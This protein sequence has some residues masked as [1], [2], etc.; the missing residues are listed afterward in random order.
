MLIN[1]IISRQTPKNV[2]FGVILPSNLEW[3]NWKDGVVAA[4]SETV[5]AWKHEQ[6]IK[7]EKSYKIS[8]S[9]ETINMIKH[10]CNFRIVAMQSKHG[11]V[12]K[13]NVAQPSPWCSIW[14]Y[15]AMLYVNF[16]CF[17][18]FDKYQSIIII[19]LS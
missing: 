11:A 12:I 16:R 10:I 15:N 5:V 7:F 8:Q 14:A 4:W 17:N 2:N 9:N 13:L 1:F 18:L 6:K 3:C 19:I